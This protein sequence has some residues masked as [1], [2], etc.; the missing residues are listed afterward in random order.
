MYSTYLM[1]II[2][3]NHRSFEILEYVTIKQ[4]K[5][6]IIKQINETLEDN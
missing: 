1:M 6:H 5:K 2:K 3:L 4:R